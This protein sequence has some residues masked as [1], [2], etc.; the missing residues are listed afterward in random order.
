[1]KAITK[2]KYLSDTER[3]YLVSLL[4]SYK[5]LR[6]SIMLRLQLFSGAR[7][8]EILKLTPNSFTKNTVTISA[9]KN[10][11][12]RT[13]PLKQS[14]YLEIIN[15]INSH[16][17]NP[18]AKLFPISSRQYSRIW[19][20]WKPTKKGTHV[21]RHTF[22]ILLYKKTKDIHMVRRLLGHKNINNTMIY[23][24]FNVSLNEIKQATKGMWN[25]KIDK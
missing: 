15:Y 9:T 3:D 23:L 6:D 8:S 20:F 10:S 13:I 25:I 18:N 17:L 4:N 12:D 2:K 22:G 5:G 19:D 11:N 21:L 14:F 7:K 16:K 24:D 1:M